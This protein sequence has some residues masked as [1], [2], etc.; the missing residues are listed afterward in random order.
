VKGLNNE[1]MNFAAT[2]DWVFGTTLKVSGT[3]TARVNRVFLDAGIYNY[4]LADWQKLLDPM[5]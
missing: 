3:P 1:D 4:T 2:M 5:V